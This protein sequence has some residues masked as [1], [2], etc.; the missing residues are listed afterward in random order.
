[1]KNIHVVRKS[2]V[3][4]KQIKK[5]DTFTEEN[6]T[7]KR[8]GTGISPMKLPALIGKLATKDYLSDEFIDE[9]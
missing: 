6:L 2:I 4:S 8:P 3:A 1:M 9:T 5:G 7:T